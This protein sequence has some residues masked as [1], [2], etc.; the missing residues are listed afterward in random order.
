MQT[1]TQLQHCTCRPIHNCSTAHAD[2]Y[3]TAALHMQTDTQLQHC[4]CRPIHNS[5]TA[6]ADRYT[7]AAL[8]MQTDTQLQHCTCRPIHNSGTAHADRYTTAALHMQTDIHGLSHLALLP[9]TVLTDPV[10]VQWRGTEQLPRPY[11]TSQSTDTASR[12]PISPTQ[13]R[14]LFRSKGHI[15]YL[16]LAASPRPTAR[17]MA[18]PMTAV[19]AQCCTARWAVRSDATR[20]DTCGC[21]ALPSPSPAAAV[22]YQSAHRVVCRQVL[23]ERLCP[24]DN[25]SPNLPHILFM[26]VHHSLYVWSE[27]MSE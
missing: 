18:L 17:R 6:H 2:R 27:W 22:L 19:T 8:H 14:A 15:K 1:D 13:P 26:F 24:D 12:Q 25:A 21:T 23:F 20:P 9:N 10:T 3:T 4:T 5:G 16:V 11:A 7:T